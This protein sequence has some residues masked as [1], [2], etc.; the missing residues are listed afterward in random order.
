LLRGG[1]AAL[2]TVN[3]LFAADLSEPPSLIQE[4][5]QFARRLNAELLVLHVTSPYPATPVVPVDPLTG[6]TGYA[7]Y[8]VYDP[9]LQQELDQAAARAY[10]TFLTSHFTLPI[11]AALREGN[12]ARVILADADDLDVG[13]IIL[14]K[15]RQSRLQ[16]F[17]LGSVVREVVE[18]T[19]RP[20]LLL[21][22]HEER[23]Q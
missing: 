3:I 16:R 14:G 6:L 2:S 15:R 5:E 17:F 9:N 13:M 11:R 12:P 4:V 23:S 8:T 7:P 10:H 22:I 19:T 21:P 20:T 18:H 1:Y